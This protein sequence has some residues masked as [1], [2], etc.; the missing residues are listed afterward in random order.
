MQALRNAQ[1]IARLV[2]AWFVCSIGVAVASPVIHPKAMDLVCS[3]GGSMKLV[4]VG[5][6]DSHTASSSHTLDCPLCATLIAPPVLGQPALPTHS[7]LAHAMQP[8]EAARIAA[9]AAPPLPSRGPPPL[10][11]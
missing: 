5:D 6:D 1:H 2:L 9:P 7:P 10:R 4:V 11:A 3:S 8:V